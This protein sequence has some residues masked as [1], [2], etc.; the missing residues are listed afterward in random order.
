MV[1]YLTES[2]VQKLLTMPLALQWVEEAHRAL[3]EQRA[4]AG[5]AATS[6]SGFKSQRFG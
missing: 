3:G 4:S 1:R 6:P 2:D 5:S